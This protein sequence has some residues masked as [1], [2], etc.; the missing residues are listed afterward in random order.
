MARR[1][2]SDKDRVRIFIAAGGICHLCGFKIFEGR[3]R[4]EVEHVIP[5]AMTRDNSD[6]NLRPAHASCHKEKTVVDVGNIAQ[7]K[8]REAR[9]M[10][11]HR[12][13]NPMPGSKA[14]GLKKRM[15]G[16]VVRRSA[17]DRPSFN[18]DIQ[19]GDHE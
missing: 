3:E 2:F 9:D 19:D 11:A 18:P 1:S 15:D 14:S 8:R 16:T 17:L 10:G 5:Y 7:A 13:R 6:E 12:S 4:W